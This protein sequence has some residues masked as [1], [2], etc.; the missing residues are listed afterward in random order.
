VDVPSGGRLIRHYWGGFLAQPQAVSR[1]CHQPPSRNG[2]TAV[3]F[4][5][6]GGC[7]LLPGATRALRRLTDCLRGSPKGP[8]AVEWKGE[9]EVAFME[10]KQMLASATR[11]AHP[12]QAAK[13]S[14][15]V[16][17]SATHIGACLQQKLA[18]SPGWEPLGFFSK[19]L[20]RAV[21]F[22][23]AS[24]GSATSGSCCRAGPSPSTRTTSRSPPPST[25]LQTPGRN[26]SAAS[27]LTWPSIPLTFAI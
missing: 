8:T 6:L 15:A 25:G 2:I 18:G 3:F 13:L 21:S 27:L 4:D 9:R 14:L 22:W 7:H 1:P 19:K 24:W 12:A 10:V 23:R 26:G 16:D 5:S 11:L 17:A 20:E